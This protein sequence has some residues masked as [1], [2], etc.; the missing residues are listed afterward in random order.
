MKLVKKLSIAPSF[1]KNCV[2]KRKV[3]FSVNFKITNRC[4]RNCQYC[5]YPSNEVQEMTTTQIISMINQFKKMGMRKLSINGGEPLLRED[6]GEIVTYVSSNNIMTVITSNGD[7]VKGKIEALKRL[8]YLILSLDGPPN[9][10]NRLR[11]EG[12]YE[13]VIEAIEIAKKAGLKVNVLVVLSKQNIDSLDFIF[14]LSEKMKFSLSFQPVFFYSFSQRKE[15][16]F[17]PEK[18]K[19]KKCIKN[20]IKKKKEGYLVFNSESYLYDLLNWP[21]Y[22]GRKCWAGY[23]FCS[24]DPSGYVYPCTKFFKHSDFLNGNKI[25]FK[26]AFNRIPPYSCEG[27][28]AACFN[29]YN[30][31]FSLR[32]SSIASIASSL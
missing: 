3:P 11:G 22:S 17:R 12:S 13:N 21:I 9:I 16:D 7:L 8:D 2:L 30:N 14:A 1:L 18:S 5:N 19:L 23:S 27:C 28:W 4:N 32:L 10:H 24:V 26:E 25:G 31:L 29:E 20:I 6:L 15:E